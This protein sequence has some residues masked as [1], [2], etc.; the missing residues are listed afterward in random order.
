MSKFHRFLLGYKEERGLKVLNSFQDLSSGPYRNYASDI[1]HKY[2]SCLNKSLISRSAAELHEEYE[3]SLGDENLRPFH[4]EAIAMGAA[5]SDNFL[6]AIVPIVKRDFLEKLIEVFGK[7]YEEM[8][9]LGW[10]W[11]VEV[12]NFNLYSLVAISSRSSMVN[13]DI[14]VSER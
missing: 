1:V 6:P 7:S 9:L 11:Y 8:I 13:Q 3:S 10:S 2:I 12:P 14:M 4:L 5:I